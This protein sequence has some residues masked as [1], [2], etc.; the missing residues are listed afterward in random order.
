[1]NDTEKPR[2][3][4]LLTAGV[5][6]AAGVLGYGL[7]VRYFS[8]VSS[9]GFLYLDIAE[10]IFDCRF[11]ADSEPR[12]KFLPFYPVLIAAFH[13]A[14]GGFL[15]MS[16]CARLIDVLCGAAV[17]SLIYL[18]SLEL[19]A[20]RR[21]ALLFGILQLAL[22]LGWDEYRDVSVL[23]LFTF[24]MALMLVLVR[25]ERLIWAGLVAGLAVTTRYEAFLFLPLFVLFNL[26]KPRNLLYGGIGFALFASPWLIR[27]LLVHGKLIHSL[28]MAELTTRIGF[29]LGDIG[30]GLLWE[31][32]LVVL[33]FFG[34]GVYKLS[35]PWKAYLLGFGFLYIALHTVWWFYDNRFLFSLCPFII[36][37][38][39]LGAE[40][41]WRWVR[42][43]KPAKAR[44]LLILLVVLL[45]A[46]LLLRQAFFFHGEW[47]HELS[48]YRKAARSLEKVPDNVAFLGSR[49]H[50]LEYYSGHQ[51]YTWKLLGDADP[52]SYVLEHYLEK[53]VGMVVW[54]NTHPVDYKRFSFLNKGEDVSVKVCLA[55]G[56]YLLTYQYYETFGELPRAVY[57]YNILVKKLK[58][59]ASDN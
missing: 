56:V 51:A 53:D 26:K 13:T 45:V 11:V 39:A 32:G 30:L 2:S 18:L 28:Y 15:Q 34:M 36:P 8:Y 9:D 55:G 17:A 38:A 46:P 23:P 58:A 59:G 52:H 31:L 42:S 50:I 16:A 24:L 21:T 4:N 43:S 20:S 1:M 49:N 54:T 5:L 10:N 33:V 35:R 40:V 27:N 3:Y 25:K 22:P 48:P 6:F 12:E 19:G 14:F 44:F 47:T 57:V 41:V 29:H 7:L 37:A